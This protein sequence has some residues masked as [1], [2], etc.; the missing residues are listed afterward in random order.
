M[1]TKGYEYIVWNSIILQEKKSIFSDF[2]VV[3]ESQDKYLLKLGFKLA[4][5]NKLFKQIPNL[6]SPLEFRD[7]SYSFHVEENY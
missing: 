7:L 5:K 2:M 1:S 4:N 6:L 3:G